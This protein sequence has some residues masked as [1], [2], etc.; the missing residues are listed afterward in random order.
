MTS[1]LEIPKLSPLLRQKV[2]RDHLAGV[3]G[4]RALL[5]QVTIANYDPAKDFD[6]IA[7]TLAEQ[8]AVNGEMVIAAAVV[9]LSHSTVDDVFAGAC[10]LAIELDP[11]KW[12]S[13]LN[14]DRNVPLKVLKEQGADGVFALELERLKKQLPNKSLP[15]RAE[16]LFRHVSIR[17][18]EKMFT[19]TDPQYFRLSTLKDADDLRNS[20]VHGSMLPRIDLEQSKNT[21]LFL[22]EA[23]STALRSLAYSYPLPLDM[24]VFLGQAGNK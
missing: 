14:L 2:L 9:V 8:T 16:L 5:K 10:D 21:M 24:P 18:H 11:T 1:A 17:H 12:I 6:K 13:E 7:E 3:T 15:R 20:I 23:A 4:L 19:P 22:H